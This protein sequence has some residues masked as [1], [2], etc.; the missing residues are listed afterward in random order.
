MTLGAPKT[1]R[2]SYK[3]RP[4]ERYQGEHYNS[5]KNSLILARIEGHIARARAQIGLNHRTAP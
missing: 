2:V 5:G 3:S 4:N 1:K